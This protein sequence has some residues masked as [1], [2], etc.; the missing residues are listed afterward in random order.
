MT[1]IK[2]FSVYSDFKSSLF[3]KIFFFLALIFL[4]LFS[5]LSI[6]NLLYSEESEGVI[7]GIVSI[8]NSSI[9][10][11]SLALFILCLGIAF[12]L[13]FFHHQFKKLAEIADELEEM[14]YCEK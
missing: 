5:I 4:V 8:A 6:F 14:D 2:Y 11:S 7:G 1:K 12:I 9:K 10:E 13:L 3:A